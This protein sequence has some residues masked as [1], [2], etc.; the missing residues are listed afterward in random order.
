MKNTS[1]SRREF[2]KL[3]GY[4][5]GGLYIRSW[6]E[7]PPDR[8]S[9]A[10][11]LIR[12][13]ISKITLYS[14]PTYK[15]EPTETRTRDQLLYYYEIIDSPQGPEF[16]P[17]WYRVEGGYAHSAYLQPV[18]TEINSPHIRIDEGGE[19]YEITVPLTQSLR[20]TSFYGWQRLYRLYYRSVHWVTDVVT[21]PNGR[22]WYKIQDDLLKIHYH[23]PAKHMRRIEPFELTP[24]SP[25]VPLGK[26][27][28][29][30]S[31]KNQTLTAFEGE[32]E[33]FHTEISSGIPN[34]GPK[35]GIPTATPR[36]SFNVQ[37][38]MPVRHMGDGALTSEVLA[39]EL[40][41]VPWVTF[42]HETGVAFHGTYW[43]DN[44]GNEMSR[45]CVNM[46]LD[47]AK[48]IYRWT[49]PEVQQKEWI[50]IGFGTKV[51]VIW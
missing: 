38:K 19:L 22:P 27:R 40:P 21:G 2:L 18:N 47:E 12:V 1:I 10:L 32:S 6:L 24:I 13:T 37:Q 50:S 42:F 26:K 7:Y 15:S 43:H 45:G 34:I 49:A 30:V 44:F 5:L 29:Q 41:G 20:Y 16:N 33:V 4:S 39:Y 9:N 8:R 11:G 25:D 17:R 23:V 46:R 31:L 3:S 28:I 36:G 51:E 14:K 35:N 48:W